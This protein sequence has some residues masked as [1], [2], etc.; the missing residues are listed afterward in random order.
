VSTQ[1]RELLEWILSAPISETEFNG[2]ADTLRWPCDTPLYAR[3]GTS[4]TIDGRSVGIVHLRTRSHGVCFLNMR[5]HSSMHLVTGYGE[6]SR[7]YISEG[8]RFLCPLQRAASSDG[9]PASYSMVMGGGRVLPKQESC[10]DVKLATDLSLQPTPRYVEL[11]LHA[12][13]LHGRVLKLE[14]EQYHC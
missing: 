5:L 3:V 14:K 6:V 11:Y 7:G 13:C 1:P 4:P 9:R 12:L 2:R 10:R 8:K